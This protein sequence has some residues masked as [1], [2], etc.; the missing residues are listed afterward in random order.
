MTHAYCPIDDCDDPGCDH[1]KASF[2]PGVSALLDGKIA[3]QKMR[4]DGDSVLQ[5]LT[6]GFNVDLWGFT[7]EAFSLGLEAG[8]LQARE[9]ELERVI[10]LIDRELGHGALKTRLL[11]AI[12]PCST[13]VPRNDVDAL[14]RCVRDLAVPDGGTSQ[15]IIDL[16][17][18]F[19][20]CLWLQWPYGPDSLYPSVES[21]MEVH[22]Y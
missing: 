15:G 17:L 18:T 5:W 3:I 16:I 7:H 11:A 22:G 12:E 8:R 21:C 1:E 19:F 9:E 2:S 14:G 6:H 20:Y 4:I 13:R 10:G